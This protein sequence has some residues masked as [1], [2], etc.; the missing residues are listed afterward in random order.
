[1]MILLGFRPLDG[2]SFSKLVAILEVTFS[3]LASF[4]P[5]DG[6]SFS[7]RYAI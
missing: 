7:K 6:E 5:L 2:E 3:H 4:R 1:M